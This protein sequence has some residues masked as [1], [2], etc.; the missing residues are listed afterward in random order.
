MLRWN[1]LDGSLKRHS[2]RY[3]IEDDNSQIQTETA[4]MFTEER[5][6]IRSKI[7]EKLARQADAVGVTHLNDDFV[8]Q[9]GHIIWEK[10]VKVGTDR[11]KF[12]LDWIGP[13]VVV[14]ITKSHVLCK[15]YHGIDNRVRR[16]HFSDVK[17]YI[18]RR[19]AIKTQWEKGHKMEQQRRGTTTCGLNADYAKKDHVS[20][21]FCFSRGFSLFG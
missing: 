7:T 8:F 13:S 18:F 16:L 3:D 5:D 11:G 2:P 15:Y 10:R 17:P 6:Q 12:T 21:G 1:T 20:D 14:Q 19:N 4:R 9:E